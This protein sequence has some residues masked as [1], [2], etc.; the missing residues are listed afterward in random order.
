[1]LLRRSYTVGTHVAYAQGLAVIV[2]C[3]C[4]WV[5]LQLHRQ[6]TSGGRVSMLV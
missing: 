3:R 6:N 1:M 4:V 5:A 2:V